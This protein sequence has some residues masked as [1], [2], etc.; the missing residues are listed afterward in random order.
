MRYNSLMMFLYKWLYVQHLTL[1]S[2]CIISLLLAI[3]I[4]KVKARPPVSDFSP[5]LFQP[6]LAFIMAHFLSVQ[7]CIILS[8]EN[9]SLYSFHCILW[10]SGSFSF[11]PVFYSHKPFYHNV[12]GFHLVLYSFLI[13]KRKICYHFAF[14]FIFLFITAIVL[15]FLAPR[16]FL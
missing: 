12:D 9:F 3:N 1:V 8:F 6:L 2:Y 7:S 11:S 10:S 5:G 14:I 16:Y 13:S 15:I 4:M